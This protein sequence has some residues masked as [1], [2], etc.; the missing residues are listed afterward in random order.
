MAGP[1]EQFAPQAQ[2]SG[3]KP[4]EQFQTTAAEPLSRTDKFL[5][6]VRDPIDGGA[7]LLT[8]MLPAGLVEAGN[9]ANN[10][11]ADKTGLVARLP[12]GGIDQQVRQGEQE[13]EARRAA[14]GESGFDGYRSLGAL[15]PSMALGAATGGAA[16][17][18]G[19][20]ARIGVGAA[21]GAAAGALTPTTGE[22]FWIDKGKQVAVSAAAGGALPAVFGAAARV[23]S[24]N[25]S[26][27]AQLAL[28]KREGVRPTLG[29]GL[30]GIANKV[31]EKLTSIPIL[32]DSIV[33]T[34]A[35]A[36]ATFEAAAINRSLAPIG[37]KLPKG[38]TGREAIEYAEQKLGANYDK[39]LTNIGAIRPDSQFNSKVASLTSMVNRARI[40]DAEKAKY[41][42]AIDKVS[43]SI[44]QHGVITSNAFK[45]LE[46]DLGFY[47]RKLAGSQNV[48]DGEIAPAVK[49]IQ[50]ELRAMLR[51]QAGAHAIELAQTNKGWANFKR[52]QKAAAAVGAEN[53]NFTPAQL[54][55]AVK[56]LD[57][58]KDKGAFAR[59]SALGQD[60]SD[61]GKAILGSKVPDS[62]TAGRIGWGIGGGLA[63]AEP[64]LLAG[65]IGGGL[66]YLS[67]AQRLLLASASSRPAAAEPAAQALRKAGAVLG[68]GLSQ[69]PLYNLR[70]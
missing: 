14:Q 20:T 4:W 10:W 52:V 62:G 3:S 31:E 34:R 22:D 69:L 65:A 70:D 49:Q 66:L 24:P 5:K 47:S 43:T 7:Q 57:K 56:T 32:G 40:P 39:V 23:V 53:G 41:F 50:E 55:N 60:L 27:N 68:P 6:G 19:L 36:N 48:Y 42:T 25:A 54:Q 30:G 17:G 15:I 18:A 29:Q 1:W 11:L 59:G 8:K 33:R 37:D 21:Q 45:T 38:V 51:R 58:S 44:D 35:G 64:S 16:A 61:A 12:E 26:K 63:Y 13:Y 28:L 67:P 46:S 2:E 9:K